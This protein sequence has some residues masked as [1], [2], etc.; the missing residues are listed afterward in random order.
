MTADPP[1]AR[2]LWFAAKQ[3]AEL[4]SE[5][6]RP[7][8]PHE[9][10]VRASVSLISAGTEILIYR[11]EAPEG[12]GLGLETCEGS[13]SFPVKYGYQVVGEVV[14]AGE[15]A[16]YLPGDRVFARHPHQEL[17]TIGT[18]EWLLTRVPD[19]LRSDRAVFVNLLEVALN[20][21]LDVPAR[22][23][24]CV[25]VYGQ[26]V[27]GSLAA[28]LA[29]RTAGTLIV[30]DPISDRREMA[31]AFGADSAVH[32]RDAPAV[33]DELS[34]S[35]GA[36]ISIE[37]SGTP[38]ALQAA[39]D[40]TGPEGTVAVLSFFGTRGVPLILAPTFHYRRQRIVS[41]QVS[42]VGSGLQPRWSFERRNAAA[43]SLLSKPW[44]MTPVSHTM[45]FEQAPE[46]YRIL[47]ETPEKAMGILL[48]YHGATTR[49]GDRAE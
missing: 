24:D 41:S 11:G 18:D 39:I 34:A 47:D 9:V 15:Q 45:P 21:L 36:D 43:F 44:L 19:G 48:A 20:C 14:A 30:V 4:R 12:D 17:F 6:V 5:A 28:Q 10:C 46:A 25:A 23:G 1:S 8:G 40:S 31:L 13:F 7:P 29:R 37:A 42:S 38:A 27:V 2:G 35:R 22:I 26:G 3:H 32:P 33:I 49:E 16:G